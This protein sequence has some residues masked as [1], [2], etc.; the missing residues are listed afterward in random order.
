MKKYLKAN[1]WAYDYALY[2][3][4]KEKFQNSSWLDWPKEY[5]FKENMDEKAFIQANRSEFYFYVFS[6]YVLA[7]QWAKCRK[8]LKE[9]GI[10]IIGDMPMHVSLDSSDVWANRKNY[11][12]V[13]C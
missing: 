7:E 11:Q 8:L 9:K 10:S 6:Q 2:M 4:V 3:T 5:K 13:K 1:T 12:Y